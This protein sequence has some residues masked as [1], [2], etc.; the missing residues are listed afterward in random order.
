MGQLCGN[1]L[2]NT[3]PHLLPREIREQQ[4]GQT[5]GRLDFLRP[6]NCMGAAVDEGREGLEDLCTTFSLR[7]S[8]SSRGRGWEHRPVST[9]LVTFNMDLE[10]SDKRSSFHKVP[11]MGLT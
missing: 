11:T 4:Q 6:A 7:L 1:I 10:E 5:Q 2:V 9:E 8:Q 3:C